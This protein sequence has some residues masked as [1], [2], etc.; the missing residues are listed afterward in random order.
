MRKYAL[1]QQLS[2]NWRR[3]IYI[4]ST[5]NVTKSQLIDNSSQPKFLYPLTLMGKE[6][7]GWSTS[8]EESRNFRLMNWLK[9]KSTQFIISATN[10]ILFP[11][12]GSLGM[13]SYLSRITKM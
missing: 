9:S 6:F 10:I 1:T 2:S 12:A 8:K 13:M 11:L 5:S 3:V 7:Y 4:R